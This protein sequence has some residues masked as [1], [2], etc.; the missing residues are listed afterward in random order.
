MRS[1]GDIRPTED[2]SVVV[3]R[4]VTKVYRKGRVDVH[5][6][7]GVSLEI[8][9]GDHVAITG[10]SGSGKTTLLNIIGG[11]EPVSGGR[12]IVNGRDLSRLN[13]HQLSVF[14]NRFVGF[15]FQ[16]YNLLPE[17]NAWQNV[18]LPLLYAGVP[19]RERYRKAM[20]A[21]ERLGLGERASHLPAELSGGEEQRVAIARALVVRPRLVL[22]DEPTGN[23]DSR[24]Q[25]EVLSYLKEL[26]QT[27]ATLVIATHNP[28]ISDSARRV[29]RL[30]DG[31]VV[32]S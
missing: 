32:S 25:A 24:A 22:A 17:L 13:D 11:L 14:R 18:A 12:C 6:L 23:L 10:P 4:D 30:S 7:R 31:T 2:G 3:L 21:L 26:H 16:S 20:E 29:V 9:S 28:D 15:I 8:A 1:S 5:A 27:G 19:A